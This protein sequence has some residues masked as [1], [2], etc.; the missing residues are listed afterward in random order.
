MNAIF[1]TEKVKYEVNRLG[2]TRNGHFVQ[3]EVNLKQ[4]TI[5]QPAIIEFKLNGHKQIIKTDT[6]TDIEQCPDCFKNR[7]DK[8]VHPYNI[9]VIRK[10]RSIIK[11]MRI[12]TEEQVRKWVT[13][14]F[15]NEKITY[16]IAPIPVRKK[17]VS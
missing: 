2:Y 11:L 12:G 14:R 9:S 6:V 5:G 3:G 13:N 10:D 8:E 7:L 15:P 4:L 17:G 1:T 16:R